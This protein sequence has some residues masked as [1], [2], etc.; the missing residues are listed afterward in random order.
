MLEIT[1]R[2]EDEVALQKLLQV[3]KNLD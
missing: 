2:T 1:I 3:I